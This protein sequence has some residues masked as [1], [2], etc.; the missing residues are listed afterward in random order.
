MKK[1]KKESTVQHSQFLHRHPP[2]SK[3]F[4]KVFEKLHSAALK[5]GSNVHKLKQTKEA[6]ESRIQLQRAAFEYYN[7]VMELVL[8]S[9]NKELDAPQK[10]R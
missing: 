9:G 10:R 6:D 4:E 7:T 2:V 3:K 8:L 1:I 5:W